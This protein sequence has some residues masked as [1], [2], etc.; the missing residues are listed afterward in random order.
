[1]LIWLKNQRKVRYR[2]FQLRFTRGVGHTT[3]AGAAAGSAD[4][5]PPDVHEWMH[6]VAV[7]RPPGPGARVTV[8][9]DGVSV[10]VDA[11]CD[12]GSG[13]VVIGSGAEDGAAADIA[14]VR[15][16]DRALKVDEVSANFAAG[17]PTVTTR[18]G[19][20]S[21]LHAAAGHPDSVSYTHLT[22]PTK[23]IV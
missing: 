19:I 21:A 3:V 18:A 23:R 16:Y 7:L 20:A 15:V 14:A 17:R 13:S 2:T 12:L 10:R 22:L 4:L 1:M 9:R 11:A 6:V 8:Y 5:G